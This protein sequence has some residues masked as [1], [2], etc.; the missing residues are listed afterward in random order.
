MLD[1]EDKL[2]NIIG[3]NSFNLLNR[4]LAAKNLL[5][6]EL[7]PHN[8]VEQCRV[9]E[10][11]EWHHLGIRSACGRY[12]W[13]LWLEPRVLGIQSTPEKIQQLKENMEKQL[14]ILENIWLKDDQ[15]KYIIGDRLTAA[16]IFGACELEQTCRKF[17]PFSDYMKF[18]IVL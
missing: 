3:I 7:Y 10:F 16:D 17:F 2:L 4:Y 8:I 6:P 1:K 18:Y 13:A 14:E 11:L 5:L 9:D 15:Q 12:F